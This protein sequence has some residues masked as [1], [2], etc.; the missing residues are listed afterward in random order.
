MDTSGNDQVRSNVRLQL[1]HQA[2]SD[3]LQ[4]LM[5][6]LSDHLD[7]INPCVQSHCQIFS[8]IEIGQFPN[9]QDLRM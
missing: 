5:N 4:T 7:E 8:V 9:P 1:D 2:K 6:Y 3:C